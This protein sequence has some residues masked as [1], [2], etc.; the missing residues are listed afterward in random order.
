M[1][2]E[3]KLPTTPDWA[4]APNWAQ[5]FAI[6][7]NGKGYFYENHVSIKSWGIFEPSF[8]CQIFL[9]G[10]FDATNWQNSLQKRPENV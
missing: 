7:Q 2:N 8:A 9:A 3:T 1:S 4:T 10:I 6:D 5:W